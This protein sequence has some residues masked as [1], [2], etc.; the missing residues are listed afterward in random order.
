MA[1]FS[2]TNNRELQA[3]F[4]KNIDKPHDKDQQISGKKKKENR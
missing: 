3:R 4:Q 2:V 1:S